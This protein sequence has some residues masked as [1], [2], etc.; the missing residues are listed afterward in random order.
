MQ[1]EDFSLDFSINSLGEAYSNSFALSFQKSPLKTNDFYMNLSNNSIIGLSIEN[2]GSM[3]LLNKLENVH[4]KRINEI[5][6]DDNN[7]LYSCS[8]DFTVKL[9]D[10]NSNKPIKV[11]K[12][13]TINF[14]FLSKTNFLRESR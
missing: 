14:I 7:V 3:R 13:F 2:G 1:K 5:L 8:N 11:F 12:S 4:D 6:I 10:L 9:F